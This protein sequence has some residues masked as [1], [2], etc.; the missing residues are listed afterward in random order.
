[1]AQ[2]KVPP[3]ISAAP[4]PLRF[5]NPEAVAKRHFF[6]RQRAHLLAGPPRRARFRGMP[7]FRTTA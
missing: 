6:E 4:F 7:H 3:G 1:V 5:A 2:G